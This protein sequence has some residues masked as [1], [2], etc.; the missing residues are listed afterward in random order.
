MDGLQP[1]RYYTVLIKTTVGGSTIIYDQNIN[2][3]IING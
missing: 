2:F 1:E 3:K